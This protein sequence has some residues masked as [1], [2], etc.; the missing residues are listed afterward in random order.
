MELTAEQS[1]PR[2]VSKKKEIPK[3]KNAEPVELRLP[4]KEKHRKDK[5]NLII[6]KER[7]LGASEFGLSDRKDKRL[8]DFM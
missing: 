8:I 2:T 3:E 5:N 7:R 1:E 4:E 6:Y